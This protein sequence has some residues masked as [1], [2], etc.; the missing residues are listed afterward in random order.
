MRGIA[1][2]FGP[3]QAL[4][5]AD[6]SLAPGE[7]HALL[8]ENGAGKSTLMHVLFGLVRSD[9]GSVEVGGRPLR[10][11]SPRDAMAAGLGMVHQ[12]F[13]Q[14]PRMTVAEMLGGTR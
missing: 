12:H 2:R 5:G 9:A 13:S 1:K 10:G 4:R 11:G 14:V 3:V 6:F 7:V 8:G